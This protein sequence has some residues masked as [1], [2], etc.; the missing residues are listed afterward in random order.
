MKAISIKQPFAS[1]VAAGHK[2]I[3]CRSWRTA[4]RGQLLICSS[5]GDYEINDGMIAPGGMALGV[6]D[7]VDVCRMTKADLEPSFIPD[8]WFEDAMKGY[9]WHVKKLYEIKP[10]AIRGKLNLF[11]VDEK[12]LIKL[13]SEF[14]DHC[15]YLKGLN[16]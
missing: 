13:P 11:E 15:V 16:T 2:T 12:Q 1:L 14:T 9:A 3:E 7:L 10:F 4:Y 8:E 5:K 6:V